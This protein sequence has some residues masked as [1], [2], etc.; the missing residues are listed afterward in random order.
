ML[1]VSFPAG[2][3]P[4]GQAPGGSV[5]MPMG[6]TT[7]N[8]GMGPSAVGMGMGSGSSQFPGNMNMNMMGGGQP[9]AGGFNH[10]MPGGSG[11]G[12]PGQVRNSEFTSTQV[13]VFV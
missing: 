11:F 7:G 3:D 5:G 2:V 6:N 10:I 1:C 13:P 9:S 8:M 4:S 12:H